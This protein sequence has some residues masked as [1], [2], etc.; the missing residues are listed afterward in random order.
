MT[1]V[2]TPNNSHFSSV[3]ESATSRKAVTP[4]PDGE[5]QDR[6]IGNISEVVTVIC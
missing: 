1:E 4:V 3:V 6:D 2:G 5:Q